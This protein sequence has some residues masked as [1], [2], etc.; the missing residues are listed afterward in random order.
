MTSMT[1]CVKLDEAKMGAIFK[2]GPP[3]ARSMECHV[4]GMLQRNSSI[5]VASHPQSRE[6]RSEMQDQMGY[7]DG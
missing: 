1:R 5:L 2:D 4:F 6:S 3:N 7:R